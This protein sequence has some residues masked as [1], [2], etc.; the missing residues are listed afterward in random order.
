MDGRCSV[1]GE[2]KETGQ[3]LLV[4]HTDTP[5]PCANTHIGCIIVWLRVENLVWGRPHFVVIEYKTGK[6]APGHGGFGYSDFL[7]TSGNVGNS[8]HKVGLETNYINMHYMLISPLSTVSD[9]TLPVAAA[10]V[11]NA[12]RRHNHVS[13]SSS[14]S[15]FFFIENWQNAVSFL[16]L[17]VFCSRLKTHGCRPS[18]TEC[19]RSLLPVFGTVYT[20]SCHLR[21]IAVCL[22]CS[23]FE[24]SPFQAVIPVTSTLVVPAQWLCHF[25]QFNRSCLFVFFHLSSPL[26]VPFVIFCTVFPLN[27]GDT[28]RN[29]RKE[30]NILYMRATNR[31]GKD[32]SYLYSLSAFG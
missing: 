12:P 4:A 23:R 18:A 21:S 20:A 1:A 16:S 11:K 32:G 27:R 31:T 22:Y 13:S 6:Q 7:G 26:T 29:P 28:Y 25:K 17:S 3:R 9:R 10:R 14:S 19:F 24:E 8:E 15:S 30:Q 2:L 5:L